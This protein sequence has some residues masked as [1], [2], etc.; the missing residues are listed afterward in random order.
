MCVCVCVLGSVASVMADC[1]PGTGVR[2]APLSMGFPRQN[3]GVGR[4]AFLQGDFPTQGS[5]H[6][7]CVSCISDCS[8]TEPPRESYVCIT[9]PLCHTAEISAVL[10][11][12]HPSV[13]SVAA[14]NTCRRVFSE[15]C[16]CSGGCTPAAEEPG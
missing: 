2:Q 1:D 14:V 10:S 11:V 9:E 8:P 16:A 5:T 13:S 3:T 6:I 4:H 15:C 7:F 12:S